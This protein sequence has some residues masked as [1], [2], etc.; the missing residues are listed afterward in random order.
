MTDHY[1]STDTTSWYQQQLDEERDY[2]SRLYDRL[3]VLRDEKKQQLARIQAQGLQGSFQNQ[4]ERDSFASLYQDR[5]NQLAAVEEQLVFGRLDTDDEVSRHIGRI[6]LSDDQQTRI[7]IDWRAPDAAPFY[8]ATAANRQG[9]ARRRHIMMSGRTVESFEDDVL[10]STESGQTSQALLSAVSAPRTGAMGDIVSTIQREQDE[11][12]RDAMRGVLVVQGGPGTGKTAV[13]L[14]R[15]AYLLYTYRDRLAKS[16]VLLV[17]PSEAFMNY[18]DQVL[19]SLGETGVVMRSL[20][21]LYPGI[22]AQPEPD[23][24]AAE[25]KGRLVMQEVIA[26]A[27]ALRQRNI[28]KTTWVTVDGIRLRVRPIQ[29]RRAIGHARESGKPH[30]QAR[31]VFVDHMV[32]TLYDQMRDIVSPKREDGLVNKADRSYLR[33]EIRQSRDVRRLLNLCWMPLTPTGLINELLSQPKYLVD[34]APMLTA[35]EIRNLLREPKAPFTEADVPLIDE[36]AVMLGDLVTDV[37]HGAKKSQQRD[38]DTAEAALENMHYTLEDIGVDGVVTAEMLAAAQQPEGTWYSIADRAQR[39]RTWTYGH[40]V[41]DEAQELSYMQW[42]MLFRRSPLRSF[43]IVGDLA[44]ASGADPSTDWGSVLEPFAPNHWRLAELTVNYRTP[45]RI[46]R[47]AANVATSAGRRVTTPTALREGDYE[48]ELQYTSPEELEEVLLA[49]VNR[50][51]QRIP[52]GLL[53]VIAVGEDY[54][55]VQPVLEERYPGQ[56][57]TG[58]GR[59]RDRNIALVTAQNAKGLEYDAVIIVEPQNLVHDAGDSV[60]NLYVA[61]T[62][63]TQTLTLITTASEAQLPAGLRDIKIPNS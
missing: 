56:I 1:A 25:I 23:P 17:G 16:G 3:D 19:P 4:S 52:E 12:I 14:H 37:G 40:V 7:L 43:T 45:A 58:T 54:S 21:T 44:Q 55:Q 38:L 18:I 15:A 31:E 60:G 63:A 22:E 41:V 32:R 2:V 59:R 61:M 35:S 6:G 36:A 10:T 62:R 48:P 39:D 42:R 5:I 53:G 28:P 24:V 11:I 57:W 27:V 34:A 9:V 47:A 26:N 46:T 20:G 51:F 33:Q 50:Q 8:Q 30:N 13:A 29:I 49:A